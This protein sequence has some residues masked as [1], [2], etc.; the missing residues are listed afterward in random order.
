MPIFIVG[1]PRSGTT[2]CQ[3][4]VSAHLG[5]PTLPETHFFERLDHHDPVRGQ[6]RSVEARN[7]LQDLAPF[8]DFA[9]GEFDRLLAAKQVSIRSL[10]LAIV[11]GQIG[12]A[13]AARKGLWV[14]KT[15]GHA[16]HL[17]LIHQLFPQAKFIWMVRNPLN[18]LASLRE[19]R[20]PGKGWSEDW[21]P[22]E[23]LCQEWS[24]TVRQA[25]DFQRQFPA[26]VLQ[27]AL[28]S[29]SAQ[30]DAEMARVAAF[31]GALPAPE[32]PAVLLAARGEPKIIQPF[33][34]WKVAALGAVDPAVADRSGRSRLDPYESW[35]TQ[36]LLAADMQTL[37]Y[38]ATPCAEPTLDNLHQR[39]QTTIEWYRVRFAEKDRQLNTKAGR[40]RRLLA[41]LQEAAPAAAAAQGSQ[42]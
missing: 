40:I 41:K 20:E 21:H 42:P 37:G 18:A 5:L 22:I 29:L 24:E 34:V 26:Q 32:L 17:P 6:L 33:E 19:L 11:A 27:V 8:L 30:P 3:R 25:L 9:P 13:A 1:F 35:R 36:T 7:L 12:D 23:V 2:L 31:V 16:L 4:L 15:P 28:E 39:M 38:A 10:F 14:E